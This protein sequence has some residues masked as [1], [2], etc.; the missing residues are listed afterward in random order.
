MQGQAFQSDNGFFNVSAPAWQI[1]AATLGNIAEECPGITAIE[2][3]QLPQ[4][5]YTTLL[6]STCSIITS[7]L[8]NSSF[9]NADQCLMDRLSAATSS[10]CTQTEASGSLLQLI[11]YGAAALLVIFVGIN[12][13]AGQSGGSALPAPPRSWSNRAYRQEWENVTKASDQEAEP[14]LVGADAQAPV[15]AQNH[16]VAVTIGAGAGAYTAYQ[17]VGMANLAVD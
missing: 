16:V 8:A 4:G 13:L 3:S 7:L 14:L 5:N 12:C 6:N 1:Q 11:G 9:S 15:A 17:G 10:S 2:P